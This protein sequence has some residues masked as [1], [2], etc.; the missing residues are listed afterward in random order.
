[1]YYYVKFDTQGRGNAPA[2]QRVYI[3]YPST[4]L[5]PM[6][7]VY[8]GMMPYARRPNDPYC[9]EYKFSGWYTDLTFEHE[10]DFEHEVVTHNMTLYAKWVRVAVYW[11]GNRHD[12]QF[13]YRRVAWGTWQEH[14]EYDWITNGSIEQSADTELKVTGSFDFEGYVLPNESDLIRVYYQFTDDYNT[15][16]STAIATLLV[17]YADLDYYDTLKGVKSSGTLDG[18]SV[19]SI[20]D[21][22]K[23]GVPETIR[24]NSNAVYE[25]EQ[26]AIECG[27]QTNTEPS[28][29]ALSA[30]HTFDAGTSYLEMVNWLLTTAGYTEAFPD[31]YGVVQMLSYAT[32]QQR[33]DYA[34]FANNDESIM[35][36][37][38]VETN[39]WQQTP[40]VVRL[41][42]N[43]DD[44]CVAAW[45]R[46]ETGSRAWIYLPNGITEVSVQP[47]EFAKIVVLLVVAAYC[48][49]NRREYESTWQLVRT[50]VLFTALIVIIVLFMQ[51]DLGSAV[52][53][54]LL[55]CISFLIPN[56]PKMKRMQ[57]ILK[58][59]FW[60][61]V[62]LVLL[63]L[64]PGG[65]K[66]IDSLKFLEP[67]QKS[68]IISAIDPFS[69]RYGEGYQLV[70]GLVS[71]ATGGWFG[72]G[73]GNS[74][75]KYMNFPAANTD[76]ILAVLVEELGFVGFAVLMTL[77]AIVIFRLLF[78]AKEIQS[79]KAR[80]IL[81]GTAMYLLIH[82]FFNIGGVTGLIPLT[83][84]PLLMISAG[85][86]STMAFMA[87]I[88]ISQA[89]IIRYKNGEI[90]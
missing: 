32:A 42:Y 44:A 56:H 34:I 63:L 78:Y 15:R 71:F 59:L 84:V 33:T 72:L 20:L 8:P 18:Q 50:P 43:T 60:V 22:K 54:F 47:S 36:P 26:L 38:I 25:A 24:R 11:N 4:T 23:I 57:I 3:M 1:M 67:Y 66:F 83:G 12:E 70:N 28:S 21:D 87:S 79:E 75:R 89:V 46:N 80:I 41:I 16:A 86:S 45:A 9:D 17:S 53:I 7:D 64:S 13:I 90:Q 58:V 76:Y 68:R 48:G 82:M 85:G 73:Y 14:E 51:H 10:W 2:A 81:I 88:G 49:D 19:L 5:L 35:Y 39:D 37:E 74:V 77:Y 29:F 52:V 27:L 62:V 40:N 65:E 55:T 61:A 6:I 30:D 31:P 69:D